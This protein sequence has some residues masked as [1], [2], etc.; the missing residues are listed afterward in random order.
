MARREGDD[1]EAARLLAEAGDALAFEGHGR[2]AAATFEEALAHAAAAGAT[3][4]QGDLAWR[5]G[6]IADALARPAQA[7]SWYDRAARFF[8]T[9]G[10]LPDQVVALQAGARAR[11]KTEGPAEALR[12]LHEAVDLAR[13]Q[14]DDALLAGAMEQAAEAAA[15]LSFVSDALA[16]YR[17]AL[18]LFTR[19][20]DD[21]G[22][23]RCTIGRAEC[24]LELGESVRALQT[25]APVEAELDL[26]VDDEIA[27][28]GLALL[29]R[30]QLLAGDRTQAS[31]QFEQAV[32]RFGRAGAAARRAHLMLAFGR[33][34]QESDGPASALPLFQAAHLDY[35]RLRDLSRVGPAAYSLARCYFEASDLVRADEAIDRALEVSQSLGDIEGLELCTELAVRIAVR[36][37]QGK[38]ALDRLR[39][40]ARVRGELGD[41]EGEVRYLL[42]ALEATLAIPDLDSVVLADEFIE[43]LR[44]SG[45][46][47]MRPDELRTMGEHLEAAGRPD[48]A[49]EV[50]TLL[51]HAELEAGRPA[52][53]ARALAAAAGY[54]LRADQPL[55]AGELWDQALAIGARL[56]LPEAEQWRI[57]REMFGQR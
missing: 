51:A 27:G 44:R 21:L 49:R 37:G 12:I 16:K 22:R 6:Q 48:H 15:A 47:L 45:T 43:A 9:E 7:A 41:P 40:A 54:A 14:G 53:G 38:L 34:L 5:L 29:A 3:R 57:D 32:E 24:E 39:L 46:R 4:L 42:R 35:E 56:R 17:E 13:T 50:L 10:A 31:E 26:G 52:E 2:P 30:F 28:R 19:L 36:M 20:G 18:R 25:L 55:E 1:A 8:A 23:V 33:A 11:A